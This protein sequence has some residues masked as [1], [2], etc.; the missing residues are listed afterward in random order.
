MDTKRSRKVDIRPSPTAS[1]SSPSPSSATTCSASSDESTPIALAYPAPHATR[2]GV[3][4]AG[5]EEP[6]GDDDGER[7]AAIERERAWRDGEGQ[8]R[9]DKRAEVCGRELGAR[10]AGRR[11][12]DERFFVGLGGR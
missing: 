5:R 2:V 10:R 9:V 12:E 4:E 6:V 8:T 3:P 7:G 11:W 1:S